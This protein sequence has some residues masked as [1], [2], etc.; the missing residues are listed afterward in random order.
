VSLAIQRRLFQ[1]F[2]EPG[3]SPAPLLEHLVAAGR[4]GRKTGN[5]FRE[6][7]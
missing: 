3:Y 6:Y 5:G 2:R 4:L 1:E 7:A